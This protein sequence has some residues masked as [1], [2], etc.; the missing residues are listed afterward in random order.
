M[1]RLRPLGVILAVLVV[2]VPQIA[3]TQPPLLPVPMPR[4]DDLETLVTDQIRDAQRTALEA[5]AKNRASR[6]AADAYGSLGRTYHAYEFFDSAEPAYLNASRL[7][8][9]NSEW[10]HLLGVLYK[11][12]GRLEEAAQALATARRL[13][14]RDHAVAI[15]LGD[16]YTTLNRLLDARE[17]F[18][19]VVDIFPAVARRGLGDVAL[20]ERRFAEAIEHYLAVLDRVP[21]ADAIHY[22]L[23]MA[24]RGMGRLDRARA[25]LER[26]G[27][28]GVHAADPLM[29]AVQALVRGERAWVM[30]GR[31]AYEAGQF[32]QAADA[33][34]K[35][36]AAAPSSVTARINLGSALVQLGDAAGAVE[37]FQ[38]AL[39]IEPDN[40][41]ANAGLGMLLVSQRRDDDALRY[42]QAAFKTAPDEA[43]VAEALIGALVR[44]GRAD[45][46]IETF[47]LASS[48]RIDDEGVQVSVSIL[49]AD[50]QRYRDAI[51]VVEDAHQ[52]F[53]DRVPTATTL[54]RLLASVPDMTLRDGRRA[55]ELAMAVNAAEPTPVHGETIAL[56]LA[57][58]GR[59]DEALGWMKRAVAE[60]ERAKDNA[61]AARLRRE[62]P[63]YEGAM[64]RP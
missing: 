15:H 37:Q 61:G 51:A 14:P 2:C 33:F 26:R 40:A 30:Q 58:L 23:A 57:E 22:S 25:H 19:S 9:G 64:C 27:P 54:A 38:A 41:G 17:Q 60:A 34:T 44:L 18:Q 10:F 12:T 11:Q 3:G 6:D 56:A 7:A 35:A 36:L 45:E 31:R 32:R 59:C 49:L 46:A 4:L 62:M 55:L 47:S 16:V 28:G 53:P 48:S 5:V 24:Y 1:E 13:Q 39:R 52:R 63:K 29:D 42:L 43:G 50:R 21:Q 8:S 20:R